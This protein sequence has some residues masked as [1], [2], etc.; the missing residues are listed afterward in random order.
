MAKHTVCEVS[1]LPPGNRRII[2]LEG[3]SIG[4]FNIKGTY[5]AVRNR[6]PHQGAELCKGPVKGIMLPSGP[7]EY[8]YGRDGEILCCPWHGWEFEI[9][10][11]K[12]VFDPAQ[13]RVKSYEVTVVQPDR[14]AD[15]KVY[16]ERYPVTVESGIVVVE[17]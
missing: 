1:E 16:L 4:V 5:Y 11:G 12:S 3:R 15:N 8:R 7:G 10:T 14:L 9:A 2:S 13:C 6:C 17:V